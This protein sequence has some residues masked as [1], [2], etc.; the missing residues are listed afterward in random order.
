MCGVWGIWG[1][2]TKLWYMSLK[3]ISG[4]TELGIIS[5][6]MLVETRWPVRLPGEW[7]VRKELS[8][9]PCGTISVQ[10]RRRKRRP[11]RRLRS[12]ELGQ[13][14]TE[15]FKACCRLK[16]WQEWP[17][18]QVQGCFRFSLLPNVQANTEWIDAGVSS[19]P[20]GVVWPEF[21]AQCS[22]WS[23][24]CPSQLF[25][26]GRGPTALKDPGITT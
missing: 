24:I 17:A 3:L 12:G 10:G 6:W 25:R 16:A 4:D 14:L 2:C 8:R 20:R 21:R 13:P 15:R 7:T 23:L 19:A 18:G 1:M 5:K 26:L 11:L 9:E 22:L